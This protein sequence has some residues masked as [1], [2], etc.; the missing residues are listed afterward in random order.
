MDAEGE[1]HSERKGRTGT[2]Q[3]AGGPGRGRREQPLGLVTRL[4]HGKPGWGREEYTEAAHLR[5]AHPT[6]HGFRNHALKNTSASEWAT[7]QLLTE[8][9]KTAE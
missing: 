3:T 9:V 4:G 1:H 6:N 8:N 2:S 7:K 5:E